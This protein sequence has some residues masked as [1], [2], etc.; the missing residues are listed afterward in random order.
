MHLEHTKPCAECPWGKN[1]LQGWLG[2]AT[3]ESFVEAIHDEEK[4]PCHCAVDYTDPD[5]E[6]KLADK[7]Y[8][9]GHLLAT[10]AACKSPRDPLHREAIDQVPDFPVLSPW[11]EF[12]EHHNNGQ[13]KSWEM[14]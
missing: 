2:N 1:S 6:E 13:L 14:T 10:R 7:P 12:Q 5:W 4:M 8:C 11:G 3:P 9:V